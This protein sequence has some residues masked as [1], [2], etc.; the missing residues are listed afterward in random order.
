MGFL[1][2]ANSQTYD[3]GDCEVFP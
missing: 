2:R 1:K 3:N